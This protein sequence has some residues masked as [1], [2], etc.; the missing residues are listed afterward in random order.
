MSRPENQQ[1][2]EA[3]RGH[4]AHLP[5][6][7]GVDPDAL[8]DGA[9]RRGRQRRHRRRGAVATA[10]SALALALALPA[11]AGPGAPQQLDTASDHRE[12][13]E[14]DG[15]ASWSDREN[16]GPDHGDGSSEGGSEDGDAGEDPAGD[17]P[18]DG[19]VT[20]PDDGADG[21]VGD[22]PDA[23]TTTTERDREEPE[24]TTTTTQPE[25]EVPVFEQLEL[26]CGRGEGEEAGGV[27]CEW[28]LS[29]RDDFHAYQLFRRPAEEGSPWEIAGTYDQ[30]EVPGRP[31]PDVRFFD[32]GG[33]PGLPWLYQVFVVDA[34]GRRIGSSNVVSLPVAD[35]PPVDGV[36]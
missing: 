32:E 4:F 34:E 33:D 29:E 27:V 19:D 21:E 30:R 3:L 25:E 15:D 2:S 14:P 22:E 17:E 7:T 9:M 12:A 24:P 1:P 16:D 20:A 36:D 28:S 13:N 11:L 8:A 31:W 5:G 6:V 35:A 18:T 26:W 23:T 10:A